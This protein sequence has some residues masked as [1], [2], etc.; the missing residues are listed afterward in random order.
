MKSPT[1]P[2]ITGVRAW[3]KYAT[4]L[5][6]TVGARSAMYQ[7]YGPAVAVREWLPLRKRNRWCLLLSGAEHSRRVLSDPESFQ[8][9]AIAIR[10]RGGTAP[11]RLSRGLIGMNGEEHRRQRRLVTPLFKPKVFPAYFP[12]MVEVVADQ[13]GTWPTGRSLDVAQLVSRISG[14]TTPYGSALWLVCRIRGGGV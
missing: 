1:G 3:C 11:S 8:S 9:S 13:L 7:R 10:G 12:Q 4:F 5:R 2:R 6:D 14:R